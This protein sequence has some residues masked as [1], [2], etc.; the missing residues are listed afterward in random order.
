MV[1]SHEGE[2]LVEIDCLQHQASKMQTIDVNLGSKLGD[3][4]YTIYV[5]K[6]ILG[7]PELFLDRLPPEKGRDYFQYDCSAV[8][9]G[10][11]AQCAW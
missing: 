9:Y 1:K 7:Q 11:T 8:V 6:G 10:R 2:I 5:G 3:R 4:S